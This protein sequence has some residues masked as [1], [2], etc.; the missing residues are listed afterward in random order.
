MSL[1]QAF[2]REEKLPVKTIQR[3]INR[4]QHKSSKFLKKVGKKFKTGRV[5]PD[6]RPRSKEPIPPFHELGAKHN[7]AALPKK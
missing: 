6:M 2:Y 5:P 4:R 7:D 1:K 3:Q